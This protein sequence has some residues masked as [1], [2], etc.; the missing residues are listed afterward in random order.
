[1]KRRMFALILAL[2]LCITALPLL[3]APAVAAD[4]TADTWKPVFRFVLF[5]DEHIDAAAGGETIGYNNG[6]RLPEL[7][8]AA[9]KL[10]EADGVPLSALVAAG[11]QVSAGYP[12]EYTYLADR[13]TE[14][15]KIY[16]L[17]IY[18]ILGN[19]E[20]NNGYF[21]RGND[22]AKKFACDDY[23]AYTE[24][25]DGTTNEEE[26]LAG[27]RGAFTDKLS[28][29]LAN[30]DVNYRA[31]IGTG[32]YV[33]P[34][35]LLSVEDYNGTVGESTLSWL[36]TNL[37]AAKAEH[38]GKPI[39]LICHYALQ[40]TVTNSDRAASYIPESEA[41]RTLLADYPEVILASGHTHQSARLPR[42]AWSLED[43]FSAMSIP[44][45]AAQNQF[46]MVEADESGNVRFIPYALSGSTATQLTAP[47]GKPL[48]Y[49]FSY[50]NGSP[51]NQTYTE[52]ARQTMAPAFASDA[53]LTV[54]N[55]TIV[56]TG[57]SATLRIP[58]ALAGATPADSFSVT[59][60]ETG[61]TT[62]TN[63][64]TTNI[65][66]AAPAATVNAGLSLKPGATY[67]VT[68]TP[69]SAFGVRGEALAV[70][71]E[72]P[73]ATETSI[74][75]AWSTAFKL[76][77]TNSPTFD[78]TAKTITY[79]GDW[80]IGNYKE[81]PLPL[82]KY[83]N[84][85]GWNTTYGNV[86]DRG[87]YHHQGITAVLPCDAKRGVL[88]TGYTAEVA[89]Y[90]TFAA[91][92]MTV[93]GGNA[94]GAIGYAIVNLTSGEVLWPQNASG[95]FDATS[96]TAT[97]TDW[98][99][100]PSGETLEDISVTARVEKGDLIAF[101]ATRGD[102]FNAWGYQGLF[103][104]IDYTHMIKR[105]LT[106]STDRFVQVVGGADFPTAEN[107]GIVW[108]NNFTVGRWN[109]T[110]TPFAYSNAERFMLSAGGGS[111]WTTDGGL[112]YT[113][114]TGED[115]KNHDA[116][117]ILPSPTG[118]SA[119][120][121]WT[122]PRTG[123]VRLLLQDMMAQADGQAFA[124]VRN[125]TDLV[126]SGGT[127]NGAYTSE[128]W[129]SC[130]TGIASGLTLKE[131]YVEEGDTLALLLDRGE[132][133]TVGWGMYG[134][135]LAVSYTA[136]KTV[137]TRVRSA[138]N[139][140]LPDIKTTKNGETLATSSSWSLVGYTD[141]ANIGTDTIIAPVKR[142]SNNLVPASASDISGAQIGVSNGTNS[143]FGPAGAFALKSGVIGGYRYVARESGI[144]DL[145]FDE[146][147]GGNGS[148]FAGGETVAYAIYVNGTKIWPAGDDWFSI[149]YTAD[150]RKT[151]YADIINTYLPSGLY[152]AQGDRVEF[153]ATMKTSGVYIYQGAG[154]VHLP[155]LDYTA[156]SQRSAVMDAAL[157]VRFL[158][159]GDEVLTAATIG[160][161]TATVTAEAGSYL[162]GGILPSGMTET[163]TLTWQAPATVFERKSGDSVTVFHAAY[164]EELTYAGLLMDYVNTYRTAEDA[165]G[166]AIYQLA[167]ATLNYGAAAQK[168]F[169][170]EN[171]ALPDAG[172]TDTEK[173]LSL[174]SAADAF[175]LT[176]TETDYT[177]SGAACILR[178]RV[179]I[180]LLLTANAPTAG[181]RLMYWTD[182]EEAQYLELAT[183]S[184]GPDTALKAYLDVLPT[185]YG[186]VW[187]FRVVDAS[188]TALSAEL[189]Y[190][191]GS[192]AARVTAEAEIAGRI[193]TMG[194]AAEAYRTAANA[195][196]A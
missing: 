27:F 46:Y 121:V 132:N 145:R 159:V 124:V 118:S 138:T 143:Q 60:A 17:P 84:Y 96:Y 10:A 195:A 177:F 167:V 80:E 130:L 156:V 77:G 146:L 7:I 103:L 164:T 141:A 74:P 33:Y 66:A 62:K 9:N 93:G 104:S 150:N 38:P 87:G 119:A 110:Y 78:G 92:G 30:S 55:L 115:G 63:T 100:L 120:V 168:R 175:S 165:L 41:L 12:L 69:V 51:A 40:N 28:S 176:G 64:Y 75:Y 2:S 3:A 182:T 137:T 148:W 154:Y 152:L 126:S 122:A 57:V 178:D 15:K 88:Y 34:L 170:A 117:F 52:T 136:Y 4:D 151:N 11:D 1:M 192:Y 48:Y 171:T 189:T 23:V 166:K 16:D 35:V 181:A 20:Y 114:K 21:R 49:A 47:D 85:V 111:P 50:T 169:A 99:T 133:R 82:N 113:V 172:L 194:A 90:L 22:T 109:G 108:K 128:T 72:T 86:W 134:I 101:V 65:W 147:S 139:D 149:T 32:D 79:N 59:I 180:K 160:G 94:T 25:E 43:G 31:T 135:D 129:T 173:A 67:T 81:A 157:G 76:G 71:I 161:K 89:G 140:F 106:L 162:L 91:S 5:S 155:R 39:F 125:F 24:N 116:P 153:L 98:A 102:G 188:G 42:T 56:G 18:A 6:H 36:R 112:Y 97:N 61:G 144:A 191:V 190:S 163:I 107:G 13:L 83:E 95:R 70:I 196:N 193:I 73:T 29:V 185:A 179:Q 174:G 68:V 8:Q 53:E 44:S 127:F 58:Q 123:Y 37:A 183:Q 45:L 187:H 158:P 14:V 26:V 142:A 131:I 184:G 105:E 186:T 54:S 19:H